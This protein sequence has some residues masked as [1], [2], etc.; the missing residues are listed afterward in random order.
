MFIHKTSVFEFAFPLIWTVPV[1]MGLIKG[2]LI[3]YEGFIV[4]TKDV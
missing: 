1:K 3:T 2:L 4:H